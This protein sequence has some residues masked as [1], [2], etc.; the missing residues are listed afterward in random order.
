MQHTDS[1]TQ[2]WLHLRQLFYFKIGQLARE[3]KALLMNTTQCQT[4]TG[5]AS[6]QLPQ[7]GQW[8][9]LLRENSAEEYRSYA[10]FGTAFLRGVCFSFI[11]KSSRCLRACMANHS[12]TPPPFAAHDA[13]CRFMCVCA[14]I[15]HACACKSLHRHNGDQH[16]VWQLLIYSVCH[17]SDTES[18]VY[19]LWLRPKTHNLPLVLLSLHILKLV[20]LHMKY[21]ESDTV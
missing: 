21:T 1:Q 18:A 12:P 4:D 3:R 8:S 13:V 15:L 11:Q 20:K 9:D 16:G 14:H 19:D 6:D 5:H 7:M 2:D 17:T 10:M